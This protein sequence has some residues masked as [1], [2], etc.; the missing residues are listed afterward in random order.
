MTDSGGLVAQATIAVTVNAAPQVAIT[1]PADGS[2]FDEGEAVPLTGTA[3]DA[4]DGDLSTAIAWSSD[5]DGDLGI[6][7][8]QAPVLVITSYSIHYTKLYEGV[9]PG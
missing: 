6:G 5:V 3:S 7:A 2:Q 9:G 8:A 1:S 4:E